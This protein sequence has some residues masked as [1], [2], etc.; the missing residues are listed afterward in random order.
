MNRVKLLGTIAVVVLVLVACGPAADAYP[1]AESGPYR[2]GMRTVKLVDESRGGRQV[3]VTVWYPAVQPPD[4]INVRPPVTPNPIAAKNLPL[5][6]H[7][8][9]GE[10]SRGMWSATVSLGQC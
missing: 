4:S 1:L 5:V 6:C 2:V 3:S 7:H 8:H 10:Y 9:D